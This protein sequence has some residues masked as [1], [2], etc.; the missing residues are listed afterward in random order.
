MNQGWFRR[1][2]ELTEKDVERWP[3]W[4]KACYCLGPQNGDPVRP[5]RMKYVH[6]VNG[7]FVED[8]G[9]VDLGS[10]IEHPT[11]NP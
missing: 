2:I 3:G 7:R 10:A 9:P 11:N 1:Q 6:V 4:L 8:R 5:C